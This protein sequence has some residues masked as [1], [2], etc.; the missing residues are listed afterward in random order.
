MS[1]PIDVLIQ[2]DNTETRMWLYYFLVQSLM[3]A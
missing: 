2:Y 3:G 1:E